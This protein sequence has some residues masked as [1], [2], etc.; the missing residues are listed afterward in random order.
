MNQYI[1]TEEKLLKLNNSC[2]ILCMKLRDEVRSHPYNPQAEPLK[3]CKNCHLPCSQTGKEISIDTRCPEFRFG[4]QTPSEG[5]LVVR[6]S[7]KRFAILMETK[8]RKN[9]HKGGWDEMSLGKI[10]DRIR[11]EEIEARI[12]WNDV[13]VQE[14]Y[15]KV[16]CELT[17]VANFCMMFY[18]NLHPEL[19]SKS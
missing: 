19:R 14:D 1:I 17:D 10:F 4:N 11:D 8:L 13:K 15:E 3:D 2:N 7:V 6:E 18:D 12:A 16:S 9:D 5:D